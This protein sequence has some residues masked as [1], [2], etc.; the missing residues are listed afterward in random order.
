MKILS[1]DFHT[2]S[3][4]ILAISHKPEAMKLPH[5]TRKHPLVPAVRLFTAGGFRST[6]VKAGA[7][8]IHL[9][10]AA[11]HLYVPWKSSNLMYAWE[12]SISIKTLI[13]VS[14]LQ[15]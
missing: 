15:P 6:P 3:T 9:T 13:G 2:P 12:N 10:G 5:C 1:R 4:A 11:H 14:G 8:N 7:I